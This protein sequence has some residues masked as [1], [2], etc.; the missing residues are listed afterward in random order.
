MPST[1]NGLRIKKS[2]ANSKAELTVLVERICAL[3]SDLQTIV[4]IIEQK[5]L[6]SR[7]DFAKIIIKKRL[8]IEDVDRR[9]VNI[10][11]VMVHG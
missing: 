8:Y 7:A 6:F 1:K 9:S 10:Q 5:G 2:S 4:D 3:E 11:R